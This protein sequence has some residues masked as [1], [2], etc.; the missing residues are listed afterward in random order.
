MK[1]R[2]IIKF[3]FFLFFII[4]CD[5]E[6]KLSSE[7]KIISFDIISEAYNYTANGEIND[8]ELVITA[9]I[10]S[11]M[12]IKNITPTIEISENAEVY[13]PSG[14]IN[15]FSGVVYILL[16]QKTD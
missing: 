16:Q 7:N 10:L 1:L 3:T 13:P 8:E 15:D 2:H 4:G 9:T 5:E 12:N 14:V 6:K 11:E